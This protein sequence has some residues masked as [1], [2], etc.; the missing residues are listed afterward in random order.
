MSYTQ[1][2]PFMNIKKTNSTQQKEFVFKAKSFSKERKKK[3]GMYA[4]IEITLES[5]KYD[6]FTQ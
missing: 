6:I 3:H 1:K 5:E 2:Y 4:V